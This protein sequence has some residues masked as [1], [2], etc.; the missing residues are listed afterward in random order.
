M[1]TDA[2]IGVDLSCTDDLSPE[3]SVVTGRR[4]IA[5]AVYR[6]LIT[7]RGRLSYDP[8]YGTDVTAFINEDVT[9]SEINDLQAAIID[10]CNK[11]E[12]VLDVDVSIEAPG[13][14][15]GADGKYT[16]TIVLFDADGPFELVLVIDQ[17]T[18]EILRIG[19][20]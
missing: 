4:L 18:V 14:V 3:C 16:I 13:G 11:D 12:R 9:V 10:E 7:P 15:V 20:E 8:D 17:V 5:E 1:A 19:V 2:E 6:R